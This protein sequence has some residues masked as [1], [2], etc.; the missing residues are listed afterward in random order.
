MATRQIMSRAPRQRALRRQSGGCRAL[1]MPL[2]LLRWTGIDSP[3][4]PPEHP[5]MRIDTTKFT[6][7]QAADRIVEELLKRR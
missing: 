3:Y 4:E 5:E 7:E 1:S 2:S 6:A